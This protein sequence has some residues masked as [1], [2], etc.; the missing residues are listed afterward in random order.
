MFVVVVVAAAAFVV[1]VPVGASPFCMRCVGSSHSTNTNKAQLCIF[2]TLCALC[3]SLYNAAYTLY[4][5]S[6]YIHM[7]VYTVIYLTSVMYSVNTGIALGSLYSP[8]SLLYHFLT[9]LFTHF[10]LLCDKL[11]LFVFTCKPNS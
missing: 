6:I 11:E 9:A 10:Y 7:Y 4:T 3:T 8:F 2:F 5:C 1:A